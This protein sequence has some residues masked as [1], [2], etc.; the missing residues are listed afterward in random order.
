M[1]Q[2]LCRFGILGT[3]NIARKNWD[4]IRN[5]GNATVVAVGSRDRRRAE[6]FIA[7]CQTSA[8]FAQPPKALSYEELIASPEVDALYVP[9][10]TGV[11]K[12]W[13]LRAATAKKHVV[14]EKPCGVNT[15]EVEEML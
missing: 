3:S 15:A 14:C 4:A 11:R 8:P 1:P 10:P 13:V 7:E 5:S 12:Q 2:R 6:Q 9:L